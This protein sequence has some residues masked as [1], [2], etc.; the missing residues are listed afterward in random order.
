MMLT[1]R[2]I[3]INPLPRILKEW[4]DMWL[5]CQYATSLANG[6]YCSEKRYGNANY[7]EKD[8]KDGK[9][10][11]FHPDLIQ[12]RARYRPPASLF[13]IPSTT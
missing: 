1:K 12:E 4:N 6:F 13:H 10:E 11:R 7:P 9:D 5:Y 3:G 2:L 8:G